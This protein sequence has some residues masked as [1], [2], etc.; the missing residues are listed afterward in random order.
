MSTNQSLPKGGASRFNSS[1][2][3]LGMV[4]STSQV[5]DRGT[6]QAPILELWGANG[7]GSFNFI[8]R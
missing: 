2:Q 6:Q 3:S 4:I 5:Q 8:T 7:V 1:T